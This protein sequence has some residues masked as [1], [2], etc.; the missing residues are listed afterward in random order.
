MDPVSP[1]ACNS[2]RGLSGIPFKVNTDNK[3]SESRFG[4]GT[5]QQHLLVNISIKK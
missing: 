1:F 5:L 2:S 3:N 4:T